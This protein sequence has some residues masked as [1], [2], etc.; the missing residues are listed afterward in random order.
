[1]KVHRRYLKYFSRVKWATHVNYKSEE[2][3]HDLNEKESVSLPYFFLPLSFIFQYLYQYVLNNVL[4]WLLIRFEIP[5]IIYLLLTTEEED[6]IL[7]YPSAAYFL[8]T[9]AI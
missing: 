6:L 8:I 7:Y 5:K 3:L 4:F 2:I 1:M 9:P